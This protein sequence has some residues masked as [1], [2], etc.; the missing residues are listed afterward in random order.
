MIIGETQSPP[1]TP[2]LWEVVSTRL[3]ETEYFEVATLREPHDPDNNDDYE[4][5]GHDRVTCEGLAIE[6]ASRI[7]AT[8]A[9]PD[10][11]ASIVLS[12]YFLAQQRQ[13]FPIE[14]TTCYRGNEFQSADANAWV[15]ELA[16]KAVT[17][18]D[19][20][21]K[22]YL[23]ALIEAVKEAEDFYLLGTLLTIGYLEKKNQLLSRIAEHPE[24]KE[25]GIE[26]LDLQIMDALFAFYQ[27]KQFESVRPQFPGTNIDYEIDN[28]MQEVAGYL[29]KKRFPYAQPN[30][31]MLNTFFETIGDSYRRDRYNRL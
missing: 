29:V 7:E 14:D 3:G 20:E 11:G 13:G 2:P 23:E 16:G 15:I 8:T 22:D 5:L 28:R 21:P 4:D 19:K 30:W 24:E 6:A 31:R 9:V 12:E 25:V 10:T 26:T 18:D 1:Q 27:A 17:G